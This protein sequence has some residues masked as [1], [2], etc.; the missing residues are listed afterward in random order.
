MRTL[1]STLGIT[2]RA[3]YRYFPERAALEGAVA[4]ASYSELLDAM[5]RAAHHQPPLAAVAAAAEAYLAFA[6]AHPAR[7]KLM[8]AASHNPATKSQTQ[9]A[10]WQFVLESLARLTGHSNND[11]AA[12][13]LWSLLHGF[14]ALEGAG[15]AQGRAQIERG[16]AIFL[17]GLVSSAET[18]GSPRT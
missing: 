5:R 13:A 8:L 15:I 2:P 3:L 9:E 4:E 14:V 6:E 1:A 16:L 17:A 18:Q 12:L 10:V 7:Y 11:D